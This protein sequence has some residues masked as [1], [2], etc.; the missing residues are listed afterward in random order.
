VLGTGSS[1]NNLALLLGY[2]GGY[3]GVMI[4]PVHLC[5]I[6]TIEH[7]RASFKGTYRYIIPA[8]IISAIISV[9]LG[10]VLWL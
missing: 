10:V 9:V 5:L 4:S 8:A 6:L 2:T 3:M 1:I 7:Y